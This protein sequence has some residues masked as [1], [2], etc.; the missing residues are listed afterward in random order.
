MTRLPVVAASEW[1]RRCWLPVVVCSL[2]F[3]LVTSCARPS[4]H[5]EALEEMTQTIM[6]TRAL[7]VSIKS[8][9]DA[10]AARSKFMV[11]SQRALDIQ[12]KMEALRGTHIPLESLRDTQEKLELNEHAFEM[13]I[14]EAMRLKQRNP[15]AVMDLRAASRL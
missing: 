12:K 1:V 9:D 4:P 13:M 15:S 8:V 10:R 14:D 5:A 7:L 2:F 6:E 11:L 3:A